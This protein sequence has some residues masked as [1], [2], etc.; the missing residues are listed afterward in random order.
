MFVKPPTDSHG[1]RAR[2][3]FELRRQPTMSEHIVTAVQLAFIFVVVRILMIG[4]G[5]T[6][7]NIPVLDPVLRSLVNV[8]REW[9][10]R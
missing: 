2:P 3:K 4:L 6:L 8:M 5:I 9:F 1:R 10:E 7:I